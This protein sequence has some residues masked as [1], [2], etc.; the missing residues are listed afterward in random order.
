MLEVRNLTVKYNGLPAVENISFSLAKGEVLGLV[1]GSGSGK[2]TIALALLRLLPEISG[3]IIFNGQ[4]LLKVS[5]EE[6]R[7]IRGK[8]VAMIFQDP[9]TSLNPVF[10]VGEQIA[11]VIRLHQGEARPAAWQ[12]AVDLLELVQIKDP[13]SRAKDYPHQF[14][15][16]MCQRVMVAMALACQPELLIADE[17]TTA[18]DVTVQ[19]E[20]LRLLEHLRRQF[21]L[22]VLYITHNFGIIKQLCDRVI[23]LNRGKIVEEGMTA[24]VLSQPGNE[25]TKRLIECLNLLK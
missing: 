24:N 18:L 15:G 7:Q 4:D 17:P 21:N 9:F 22:S 3:E 5:T 10:T 25:Y 8:K 16:G 13:R 23:V 11:E 20:V 2:S 6:L 12:K 19:A 14:S 1:G